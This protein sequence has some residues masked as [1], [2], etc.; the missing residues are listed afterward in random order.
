[1]LKNIS[2]NQIKFYNIL[3]TKSF[4]MPSFDKRIL[5]NT[6]EQK[7]RRFIFQGLPFKT[8]KFNF[9]LFWAENYERFRK[10]LYCTINYMDHGPK[11]F[12]AGRCLQICDLQR[13]WHFQRSK[14]CCNWRIIFLYLFLNSWKNINKFVH[15]RLCIFLPYENI[16]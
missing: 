5:Q 2:N 14:L 16:Q 12:S 10:L 15:M 6:E 3:I 8:W 11:H 13:I 1:M 9:K 7:R 4:P